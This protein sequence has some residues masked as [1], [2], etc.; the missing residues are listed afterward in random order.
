MSVVA[1]TLRPVWAAT[2]AGTQGWVDTFKSTVA[3]AGVSAI[4]FLRARTEERHLSRDP[5]YVRYALFARLAR[6]AA[7]GR[8]LCMTTS[9]RVKISISLPADLIADVDRRAKTLQSGG[10]SRVIE[11]WLRRGSRAQAEADL[12]GA[13]VAYYAGRTVQEAAEDEAL[14]RALSAASRRLVIDDER[15]GRPARAR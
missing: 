12:R 10:R 14:S 2:V 9:H 13:V 15:P 11:T 3:L 5:T 6:R 4:Y 8:M 7:A 1:T